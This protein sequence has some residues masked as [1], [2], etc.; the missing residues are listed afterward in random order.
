M[1]SGLRNFQQIPN[2]ER[3]GVYKSEGTNESA[4]TRSRVTRD[5]RVVGGEAWMIV[6]GVMEVVVEMD[7]D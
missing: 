5:E 6:E 3:C 4:V 7:Q 2:C 1:Q